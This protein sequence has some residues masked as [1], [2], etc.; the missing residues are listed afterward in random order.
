MK[1]FP[2]TVL[3]VALGAALSACAIVP[4]DARSIPPGASRDQVQATLGKPVA[5]RTLPDGRTAWYYPTA[6]SG[7]TTWRVVFGAG[8]NAAEYAQVL[9]RENFEWMREGATREEV[10]D[11]VG[12]P[13]QAMRFG[14]TG[15]EAWTYRWRDATLEMIAEPVF[16]SA[17]GRVKYVGIFRDPAF[18]STMSGGMR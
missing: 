6:P 14:A 5:A 3:A 10:L 4:P 8:G 18:S 15:T 17:S 13:M 2:P 1:R 11:R 16:D 9:T 7:S 12:P